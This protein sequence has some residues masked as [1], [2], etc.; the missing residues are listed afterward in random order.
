MRVISWQPALALVL[1]GLAPVVLAPV[2]LAPVVLAPALA[3]DEAPPRQP[4]AGFALHAGDRVVFYGDSITDQRL[5]TTFVE[6]Y[7]VTR[8]PGLD[9]RFVH[10]G[11]GGDRVSG[12]IGGAIDV[13]LERDVV[14]HR[15]TLVTCMLGM[16]D[17]G[18]RPFEPAL[19]SG[20]E[21]GL[22]RLV[23]KVRAGAPKV[24]LWL[25]EPSPYD[26]VTR[27]PGLKDGQSYE[28]VLGRY[29]A[30]VRALAERLGTGVADLDSAVVSCLTRAREKDPKLAEKIIPDRVHPG[31]AGH[32]VMARALLGAWGAPALVSSVEIDARARRPLALENATVADVSSSGSLSWRALEGSLPLAW[33]SK[34]P[35]IPLALESSDVVEALDREVLRV[36]NLEAPAATLKI[37]GVAVETFSRERWAEGVNLATL[38]TPMRT[39]ALAVHAL[40]LRHVHVHDLR[41]RSL[42]VPLAP[43]AGS[44][45]SLPRALE[46]LDALEED[47]V[48]QQRAK[49]RPAWHRFELVPRF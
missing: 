10:S 1:L 25:I 20:Y 5:Y 33:D 3:Q 11:W 16:N 12:G 49:A 29:R 21:K 22:E 30:S 28:E 40:T 15:P 31:P 27:A 8:F 24:R 38:A 34:D 13:R 18:Y 42:Q 32:L 4:P 6:T 46:T 17:A 9:V 37:D 48:A 7:V 26:D 36:A 39:Q 23:E 45:P 44:L 19:L 47:A 41:W 14:A 43:D 35:V 2:A